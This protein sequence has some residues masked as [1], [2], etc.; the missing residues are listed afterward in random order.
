MPYHADNITTFHYLYRKFILIVI[1]KVNIQQI[2]IST[3]NKKFFLFAAFATAL[4]LTSCSKKLGEFRAD[5]FST[6]PTPLTVVGDEVGATIT[7]NIP[8]K[9]FVKDAE[10]TVTPSLVSASQS[11]SAEPVTVQGEKVRGNNQVVSFD[12]GGIVTIPAKYLYSDEMMTSDLVLD[13]N[14]TQGKKNYQ[15]PRV[16]VGYGV[17][18][19][20]TLADAATVNPA[21]APDKFQKIINEKYDADIHF[22]VN[23]TNIRAS[24]LQQAQ[25]KDL[26][27]TIRD[28]QSDEKKQIEG[29]NISS[30]ASPE[31][32]VKVNTRIAEGR[33][34]STQQYLDNELKKNNIT[35]AGSLTA[36]FTPQDWEGFQ[37]LVAESNIQDKDLILSVLSMYKDPEIREREIRNLSSVFDQL[38]KEVLPKL[39]YSRLTA[40]INTIGKTDEEMA[41]AFSANPASLSVEELLHYASTLSSNAD[42]LN[43]YRASTVAY[44]NDYRTWNDLG[45]CQYKAK[46]YSSALSSFNK[47]LSLN[48]QCAEAKM[49]LGLC[50]MLN[51]D[52][53][54]ANQLLGSAAGV[55]E[56]ND[57]L[58][59]YYLKTGDYNAAINA[60]GD[61]KTN[62]SALAQI[63]T[64]DYSGAKNTLASITSPDAI[65]YYLMAI[66]GART[67]NE[68]MVM[69]NLRQAAKLDSSI[70]SR[71]KKDLEFSKFNLSQLF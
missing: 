44:P 24:E 33:E 39:R 16:K 59:V 64:Q 37:K 71:A 58:G 32:G 66:L 12:H 56:L 68:T 8:P 6:N 54:G 52:L 65:T 42:Q 48:P 67:N 1:I 13:F 25:V 30:Y 43:A 20:S 47:A 2:I 53:T 36:D 5:Y 63:I 27:Q 15:L 14:V 10:V 50:S 26:Q 21:L 69:G 4:I 55:P 35:D 3:M 62:N 51:K 11:V 70:I 23:Q 45:L 28:A 19:T 38:A 7:A 18:A 31:G 9:F 22:L 61:T 34:K 60:F 41:A 17:N 29:I 49:N 46:D 57:A 40:S